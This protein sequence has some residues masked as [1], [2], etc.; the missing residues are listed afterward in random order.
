LKLQVKGIVFY[1]YLVCSCR[2]IWSWR[3]SWRAI[4]RH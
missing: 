1:Y 2:C 4:F 3:C